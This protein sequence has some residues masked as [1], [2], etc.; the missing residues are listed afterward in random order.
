[1]QAKVHSQPHITECDR[2]TVT[3]GKYAGGDVQ[4]LPDRTHMSRPGTTFCLS[5]LRLY[6]RHSVLK[7][8]TNYS[9]VGNISSPCYL[10]IG[11]SAGPSL[12]GVSERNWSPRCCPQTKM[13]LSCSAV[14]FCDRM[15]ASFRRQPRHASCSQSRRRLRRFDGGVGFWRLAETDGWIMKGRAT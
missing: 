11:W 8:P 7:D 13:Q 4:K 6:C 9:F 14:A 5:R 10:M 1:M 12:P 3:L 15:H 2:E